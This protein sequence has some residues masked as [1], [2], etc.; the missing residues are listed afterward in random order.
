MFLDHVVAGT[1]WYVITI[2]PNGGPRVIRKERS[3]KL[4]T[5]V[6]AERIFT[7]THCIANRERSLALC[8]RRRAIGIYGGIGNGRRNELEWKARLVGPSRRTR[9]RAVT[10]LP[11]RR[12]IRPDRTT[13]KD[14]HYDQPTASQL[15]VANHCIPIVACFA[16]ASK[17][18]KHCV[19]Y[20]GAIK[21]LPR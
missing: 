5:I 2:R 21:Y 6:F 1:C 16:L 11:Y 9:L 20:N 7:G 8:C 10:R 12:L 14:R 19:G 15:I 4:V 3:Q 13:R 17:S 18:C